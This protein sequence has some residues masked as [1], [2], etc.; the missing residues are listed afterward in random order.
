MLAVERGNI[1]LY[2]FGL[3]ALAV[4][5]AA[6]HRTLSETVLWFAAVLKIFPVFAFPV[7]FRENKRRAVTTLVIASCGFL[8][9]VLATFPDMVQI[10]AVT[11]HPTLFGFGC[12]TLV[13]GI[14]KWQVMHGHQ[15]N[16]TTAFRSLGLLVA[17]A[18]ALSAGWSGMKHSRPNASSSRKLDAFRAGALIYIGVFFIGNNYEYRLIFLLLCLGQLLMWMRNDLEYRAKA[19]LAILALLLAVWERW[20]LANALPASYL[21]IPV[22]QIA[23]WSLLWLLAWF[24]GATMPDWIVKML[25]RVPAETQEAPPG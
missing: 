18:V 8:L 16:F 12:M 9:Y 15:N 2:V 25:G 1:D 5:W 22:A 17:L 13:D 6:K 7:C 21:A 10:R 20:P 19:A 14:G 3:V 4:L 11:P 23:H 24:L